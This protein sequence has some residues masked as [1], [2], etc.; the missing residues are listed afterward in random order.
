[1]RGADVVAV[2]AAVAIALVILFA[3]SEIDNV[4]S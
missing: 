4:R 3:L 2:L 1:L